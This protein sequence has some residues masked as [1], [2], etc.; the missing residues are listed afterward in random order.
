MRPIP[1]ANCQLSPPRNNAD[2]AHPSL[3]SPYSDPRTLIIISFPPCTNLMKD[4]QLSSPLYSWG[5]CW[6]LSSP[7]R[8][9][10]QDGGGA[11]IGPTQV[12]GL[13]P[14]SLLLRL[15]WPGLGTQESRAW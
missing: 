9:L 15:P 4:G 8:T 14:L 13:Q 7:P 1:S 6:K 3:L 10:G 11:V 12:R 2:Y 5:N